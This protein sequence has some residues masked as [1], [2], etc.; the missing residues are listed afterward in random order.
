VERKFD[1]D[2]VGA[3]GQ[4]HLTEGLERFCAMD[5]AGE[6]WD[7]K[8]ELIEQYYVEDAE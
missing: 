1:Q 5:E 8:S 6:P 3:E 7:G 4:L 2:M